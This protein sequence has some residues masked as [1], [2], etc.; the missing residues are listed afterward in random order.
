MVTALG[1]GL[2]VEIDFEEAALH[3][4]TIH[5]DH[6]LL[7]TLMLLEL[8]VGKAFRLLSLPVVSNADGLNLAKSP[9]PVSNV[10]LFEVVWQALD[11]ERVAVTWH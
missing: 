2:A 9:E 7:G 4:F 11:E 1:L 5:L 3:L 6:G 8:N 10:V